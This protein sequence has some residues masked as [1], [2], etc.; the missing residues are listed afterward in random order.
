K[1]FIKNMIEDDLPEDYQVTQITDPKFPVSCNNNS[2]I[3]PYNLRLVR[4]IT[5]QAQIQI[6]ENT[7]DKN[8]TLLE[9][10]CAQEGMVALVFWPTNRLTPNQRVEMIT[11]FEQSKLPQNKLTSHMD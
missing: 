7:T 3:T 8:I 11:V 10:D 6:I 2:R 9:E 5:Y 1:K 4:N